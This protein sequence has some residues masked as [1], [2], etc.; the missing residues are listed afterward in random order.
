MTQDSRY[1]ENSREPISSVRKLAAIMFTDIVGYTTLMGES[2]K[3]AFETINTNREI[4]KRLTQKHHGK[5][6]KELG[7]GLLT[8][9]ENGT[10]AVLCAVDIQKEASEKNIPLRIGIHEGE[11]VFENEDVYGDGVNIASRIQAE[12]APG[13][14]CISDAMYRIIR[15]KE[16]LKAVSIG[17][18][19]L[20]NVKVPIQLYQLKMTGLNV[21]STDP[22]RSNKLLFL[23]LGLLSGI[24]ISIAFYY[25]L[26]KS[27][28]WGPIDKQVLKSTIQL[29]ED[30]PLEFIGDVPLGYGFRSF[31]ISKD[32]EDIVYMGH[33]EGKNIL[34]HRKVNDFNAY[35]VK[36]TEG[37]YLPFLSPDKKWVGF[38]VGNHMK[39]VPL[40][41]GN[42]I[43]LVE[44]ANPAGAIWNDDD[45]IYFSGEEGLKF[46]R[47]KSSGGIA[48]L[49]LESETFDNIYF[50][51]RW[52]SDDKFILH[53]GN[54][55][56]INMPG[57]FDP[58]QNTYKALPIEGFF[59]AYS[60]SGQLVYYSNDNLM[61]TRFDLPKFSIEGDPVLLDFP[62][63][64]VESRAPQISVSEDGILIFCLGQYARKGRLTW[65][66]QKGNTQ[67][68]GYEDSNFGSF[69]ISPDG[70]RVIIL[71]KEAKWDT[72]M[73]D[74]GK[75][76]SEKL[77]IDASYYAPVF[78]SD[79][80]FIFFSHKINDS[81]YQHFKYSLD[82]IENPVA[83]NNGTSRFG[84]HSAAYDDNHLIDG[85]L[86]VFNLNTKEWTTNPQ[87]TGRE[88][89]PQFSKNGKYIAYTSDESGAYQVYIQH[90][91][92]DGYKRQV[93][94]EGGSEEPRWAP[95][96]S[97]L[98]FR[99]GQK[100]MSVDLDYN[101]DL[102]IGESELVFE[103]NFINVPGHSYDIHPD[104]ARF[105]ILLGDTTHTTHEM[106]MVQGWFKEIN[107]LIVEEE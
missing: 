47:I 84:I 98:Y 68:L 61:I 42:P 13:G 45:F 100:I 14:V 67:D 33:H 37:A 104:G 87:F 85:N 106:Q 97:K 8:V 24:L 22:Y 1:K 4:H 5:I 40:Q 66:D 23:V 58:D 18:K 26:L 11:V 15:N 28:D 55:M 3:K 56:G 32:G 75:K 43:T 107:Q 102:N 44:V 27:K 79:G 78:S 38:F 92:F 36:G 83:F 89:G 10:E 35:P 71:R 90:F 64:R 99:N 12:A 103:T 91:P 77:R 39:K 16:E 2:E 65:V 21:K 57:I 86:N 60:P 30:Y 51:P 52:L 25:I 69:N 19:T 101:E 105:L 50:A 80:K 20:K 7:D 41:G 54:N 62:E 72:W 31:I 34:V 76:R 81:T 9:F 94:I 82:R 70:E 96:D 59:V 88:W 95:D 46:L 93:S 29:P 73:Y 48:E 17:I 63:I 74:L 6:V 49:L 53:S